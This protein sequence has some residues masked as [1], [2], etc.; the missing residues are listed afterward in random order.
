MEATG[1]KKNSSSDVSNKQKKN[2]QV[3]S[4]SKSPR[5]KEVVTE[6]NI[7]KHRRMDLA[8]GK[9]KNNGKDYEQKTIQ[10]KHIPGKVQEKDKH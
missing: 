6:N 5:V 9:T 3:F 2:N 8:E 7:I 10:K 1:V 4:E